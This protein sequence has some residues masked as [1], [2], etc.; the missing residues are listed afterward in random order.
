MANFMYQL[1]WTKGCPGIWSNTI[2][3]VFLDE[4]NI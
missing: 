3:G 2:L 1:D 4:I